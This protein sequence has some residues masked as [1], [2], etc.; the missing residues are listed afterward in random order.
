ME[1]QIEGM[2]SESMSLM[3]EGDPAEARRILSQ[4]E[5]AQGQSPR[6]WPRKSACAALLSFTEDAEIDGIFFLEAISNIDKLLI[7][8]GCA[9]HTL[10][11]P[12]FEGASAAISYLLTVVHDYALNC[13]ERDIVGSRCETAPIGGIAAVSL[14]RYLFCLYVGALN[15]QSR[16]ETLTSLYKL[17]NALEEVLRKTPGTTRSFLTRLDGKTHESLLTVLTYGQDQPGHSRVVS[18]HITRI[19]TLLSLSGSATKTS[20]LVLLAS[21]CVELQSDTALDLLAVIHL[22]AHVRLGEMESNEELGTVIWTFLPGVAPTL[23]PRIGGMYKKGHV[24]PEQLRRLLCLI[25]SIYR[26]G[27]RAIALVSN[28]SYANEGPFPYGAGECICFLKS[29]SELGH[30]LSEET[31]TDV[32][33]PSVTAARHEKLDRMCRST[34]E[35]WDEIVDRTKSNIELLSAFA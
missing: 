18:R 23:I 24:D 19:A 3:A 9:P 8:S 32:E 12:I 6:I 20:P 14:M 13:I 7:M 33:H 26:T 11:E 22:Q 34:F 27:V 16:N 1:D 4:I 17:E 21:D 30:W 28:K 15:H 5:A 35:D 25:Q 10:K 2:I 29:L 31:R